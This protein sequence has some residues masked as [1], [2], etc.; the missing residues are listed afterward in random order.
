MSVFG[1]R[2]SRGEIRC[3]WVIACVALSAAV[4]NIVVFVVLLVALTAIG[5]V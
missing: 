5:V 2:D 3:G 4:A 1:L